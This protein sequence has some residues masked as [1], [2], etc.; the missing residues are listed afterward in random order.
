MI[1]RILHLTRW[2]LFK[3]RRLRM[4]WIIL[5]VLVMLNQIYFWV[6]YTTM[7]DSA[8]A[9]QYVVVSV[10]ANAGEEESVI[11]VSCDDIEDGTVDSL[12]TDVPDEFREQ[13]RQ[14][15]ET[16]RER[17]PEIRDQ[18]ET[19]RQRFA[20]HC[21]LP[22]SL[23]NGL[24]SVKDTV[25]VLVIILAASFFGR[26]Y[27]LGTFRPVM[28]RGVRRWEFLGAKALSIA[29]TSGAG[30]L[31]LSLVVVVSSLVA[32]LLT[33]EDLIT[34]DAGQWSSAAVLF[35]K[36]ICILLPY[37]VVSL[38]FTVLTSSGTAGVSITLVHLLFEIL[39]VNPLIALF[40]PNVGDYMLA[41][42][43]MMVS[44]IDFV[45]PA[46]EG[47]SVFAS[48]VDLY[49]NP[50]LVMFAYTVVTGAAAFWL[51]LRRDVTGPRGE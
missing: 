21:I 15:V 8:P 31:I 25:L 49:L 23:A 16:L 11:R 36:V 46:N 40:S 1:R 10:P 29:L 42:N 5:A 32:A 19:G 3:L 34:A 43:V 14:E 9:D 18:F 4:P 50:L 45:L 39:T 20:N 22:G 41:P 13:A 35:G 27:T 24:K 30:L 17:C 2:E 37:I 28:S 33:G 47:A 51:F 7:Y 26:E 12:L 38:F 6:A 44:Q 48:F